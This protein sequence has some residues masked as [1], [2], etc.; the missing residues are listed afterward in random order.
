MTQP[1]NKIDATSIFPSDP[2]Q[3][4]DDQA[5]A[6][7]VVQRLRDAGHVALLAGGCVRDLLLGNTPKD[8]DV[9]TS[10]HPKQVQR[11][12]R[13]TIAVG[14]SFG[15]IRVLGRDNRIVEVATFRADLGYSDGRHPD[16]VR[17]TD[18]REDALRRDFTI[19]G[20]F[21]DPLSNEVHDFVGGVDDLRAGVIRAIGDAPTRFE[22]DKLRLLRAVRF[23]ARFS[24]N[25]EEATARAVRAMA[26]QLNVVS[27]ERILAEL[28]LLLT[29][30]SR[31]QGAGML[32]DLCL[33]DHALPELGAVATDEGRWETTCRLLDHWH[34]S[35]SLPLCLAALSATMPQV[36]ARKLVEPFFERLHGPNDERDRTAWLTTHR[37]GFDNA[38]GERPARLKRLMAHVGGEELL[39]LAEARAEAGLAD[40]VEI[41]HAR[42]LRD[43]WTDEEVDPAPLLKGHDLI[44]AGIQPGPR[45]GELLERIRDEQLDGT[46]GTRDEAL[47]Y[48]KTI[49]AD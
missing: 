17:F 24:F 31:R 35:I 33:W 46:I 3:M 36:D 6:C 44:K 38:R 45:M 18:P 21:L 14:V 11:L 4:D 25:V 1:P 28:R 8:Y 27:P 16:G 23:A 42:R 43:R 20:M 41:T 26:G 30:R 2:D 47:A 32:R 37:D 34:E 15:V 10:A 29:A 12:F 40:D 48:L 22:E 9:A 7:W 39:E 13:R 5:F 49:K 19:N